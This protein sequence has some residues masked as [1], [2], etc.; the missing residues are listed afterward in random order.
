[1]TANFILPLLGKSFSTG[2]Q[3]LPLCFFEDNTYIKWLEVFDAWE[4]KRF[5]GEDG[6]KLENIPKVLNLDITMNNVDWTIGLQESKLFML[7]DTIIKNDALVKSKKI[8]GQRE[9]ITLNNWCMMWKYD[10]VIK[11]KLTFKF[12][13]KMLPSKKKGFLNYM[14]QEWKD[15]AAEKNFTY[16]VISNIQG[17]VMTLKD[18]SY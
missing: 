14:D 16:V 9:A 15:L 4:L 13:G 12:K 1:M 6:K 2:T 5:I 11:N 3:K 10:W 8:L 18:G 17:E 7:V